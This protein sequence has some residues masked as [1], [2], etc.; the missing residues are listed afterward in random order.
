MPRPPE[1]WGWH[2]GLAYAAMMFRTPLH[3][4][5]F[6]GC[7]RDSQPLGPRRRW[8]SPSASYWRNGP[9]A[10]HASCGLRAA[11]GAASQSALPADGCWGALT[12]VSGGEMS[13]VPHSVLVQPHARRRAPPRPG[14]GGGRAWP[15]RGRPGAGVR[16]IVLLDGLGWALGEMKAR[17]MGVERCAGAMIRLSHAHT[18]ARSTPSAAGHSSTTAPYIQRAGR[19]A[20]SAQEYLRAPPQQR[21]CP[22]R[23]L[24]SLFFPKGFCPPAQ[25]PSAEADLPLSA[26]AGR[27]IDGPA[28]PRASD[29]AVLPDRSAASR[30]RLCAPGPFT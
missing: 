3:A 16:R 5:Q 21:Y 29:A 4:L 11:T 14:P 13:D 28:P 8:R 6:G 10:A 26:A 9:T 19:L 23:Q 1:V 15:A 22:W 18:T 27:A 30:R 2:D 12:V 20:L 24:S 7:G 17:A 25:S